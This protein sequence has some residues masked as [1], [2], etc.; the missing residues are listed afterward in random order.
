MKRLLFIAAVAALMVLSC[1]AHSDEKPSKPAPAAVTTPAPVSQAALAQLGPPNPRF[2]LLPA[3][4]PAFK[5][6]VVQKPIKCGV[7]S[8]NAN[9]LSPGTTL[10]FINNT[11]EALPVGVFVKWQ[12]WGGPHG[13]GAPT[14][15]VWPANPPMPVYFHSFEPGVSILAGL[16]CQ[17]WVFI[18]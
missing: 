7:L 18:P 8:V 3:R 16:P 15:E 9:P 6:T 5:P 12:F 10:Y 14:T 17:A 13:A 2:K 11:G 4:L 1:P